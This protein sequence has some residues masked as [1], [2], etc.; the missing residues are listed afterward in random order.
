[1]VQNKLD[2]LLVCEA[3][4]SPSFEIVEGIVG[5][6]EDTH[7]LTGAVELVLDLVAHLGLVEEA[8]EGGV[9]SGFIE[10]SSEVGGAG[11]RW[12]RGC[13]GLGIGLR[14]NE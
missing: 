11:G 10:D 9:L 6:G 12:R 1:M 5:R 4:Y 8:N 7:A 3:V 2:F 14:R 13:G